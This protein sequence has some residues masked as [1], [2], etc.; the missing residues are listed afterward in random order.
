M[1][2]ETKLIL[3]A[4]AVPAHQMDVG[5]V[6]VPCGP[7]KYSAVI[8][9][10]EKGPVLDTLYKREEYALA[11]EEYAGF[12]LSD[13]ALAAYSRRALHLLGAVR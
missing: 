7:G 4:F 11:M 9:Y 13:L 10:G 8:T 6:H 3:A 12:P 1:S 2:D 5:V